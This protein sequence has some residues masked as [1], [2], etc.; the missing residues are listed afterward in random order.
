M[1]WPRFWHVR[2]QFRRTL[3]EEGSSYRDLL[4]QVRYQRPSTC[5]ATPLSIDDIAQQLAT[6][7]LPP[8]ST[9]SGAGPTNPFRISKNF[10]KPTPPNAGQTAPCWGRPV[11]TYPR[12]LGTMAANL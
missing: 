11:H 12:P 2:A 9:P 5:C 6:P 7:K 3:S 10:C 1:T 4:A 8:S